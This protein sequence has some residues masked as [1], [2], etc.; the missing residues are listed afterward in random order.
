VIE[1]RLAQRRQLSQAGRSR[2]SR[3][4]DLILEDPAR[5]LHRRQLEFQLGAEMRVQAALA[6]PDRRGEVPDRQALQ[7]VD[8]GQ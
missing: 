7:P 3:L 6:H 5:L 2:K 4:H 8:G 1:E